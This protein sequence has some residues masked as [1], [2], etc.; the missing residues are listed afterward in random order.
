MEKEKL[1]RHTFVFL[2]SCGKERLLRELAPLFEGAALERMN[3]VFSEKADIP[4]IVRRGEKQQEGQL[5]LGFVPCRRLPDGNRMRIAAY[6]SNKEVRRVCSVYEAAEQE[7]PVRT[8]CME[9]VCYARRLAAELDVR[10]GVLGSAG[11]EIITGLPYTDDDSDLDILLKADSPKKLENFSEMMQSAFT[12]L[13][14]DFEV[15]L[16]NGYGIKLAELFM[17]TR[18]LIG[19]SLIDVALF[20]RDEIN[21]FLKER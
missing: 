6:V 20:E 12:G 19:K 8:R 15:E 9:A 1:K 13:D 16:P 5:A 7:I 11:L 2:T 10:M 18:T 4:G 14:M 21:K 3:S 17:N